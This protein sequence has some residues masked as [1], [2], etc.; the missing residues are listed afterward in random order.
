MCTDA[1]ELDLFWRPL[2]LVDAAF[3]LAISGI[4]HA[5]SP[6]KAGAAI[7]AASFVRSSGPHGFSGSRSG[8]P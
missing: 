1:S 3:F 4:S 6:G 8:L 5:F 7:F 2:N